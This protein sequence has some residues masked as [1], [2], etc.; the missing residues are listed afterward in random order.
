[1]CNRI[2]ATMLVQARISQARFTGEEVGKNEQL[3]VI[4]KLLT[5]SVLDIFRCAGALQLEPVYLRGVCLLV[6]YYSI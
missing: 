4:V 3:T 5:G 1:M 6:T 2:Y